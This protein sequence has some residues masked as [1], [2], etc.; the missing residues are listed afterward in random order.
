MSQ[1][2]NDEKLVQDLE[3]RIETLED[4]DEEEFGSF[5][6]L[7]YAILIVIGVLIPALALVLAR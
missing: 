6:R 4:L 7:D 3:S 1:S 5:T 2:K